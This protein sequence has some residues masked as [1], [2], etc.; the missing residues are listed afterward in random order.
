MT[1]ETPRALRSLEGL[2]RRAA[3]AA[4]G[5][6]R[7]AEPARATLDWRSKGVADFVSD[8]DVNAEA[9]AVEVL[10]A[11]EPS[12][13]IL[14]EESYAHSPS[15]SPLPSPSLPPVPRPLSAVRCPLFILDPLDGTTN[16]LHGFPEYAVSI[17]A[18]VDGELA[19][20]VVLNVPRNETFSAVRGQGAELDGNRIRVSDIDDPGRALVGTGFPFKNATDIPAYFGQMERIMR[21]VAGIRRPGSAAIDLASVAAGRLDGFWEVSLSPWDVAAGILLVREAGGVSTD[22]AGIHS[23]PAFGPIAAANPRLHP[24]LL[25]RIRGE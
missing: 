22:F 2:L 12:A 15:P 19:A 8:V 7:A 21:G 18:V 23:E 25:N 24:W 17:A 11:A 14:A 10:L 4:A 13:E 5:V 9:A 1:A 6:I 3:S 16:F 20:G